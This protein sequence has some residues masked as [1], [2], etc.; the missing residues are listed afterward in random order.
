[1]LGR[2]AGR[3]ELKWQICVLIAVIFASL[4]PRQK[5]RSSIDG[6]VC[7]DDRVR[8]KPD[9]HNPFA[10]GQLLRRSAIYCCL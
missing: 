8:D 9:V 1:M 6:I 5:R 2:S 3:D 4:G 10:E 7:P